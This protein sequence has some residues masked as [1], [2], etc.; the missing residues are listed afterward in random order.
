MYVRKTSV[1]AITTTNCLIAGGERKRNEKLLSSPLLGS[2][3][4]RHP[5]QHRTRCRGHGGK[6]TTVLRTE[7]ERVK[8]VR[9]LCE[10]RKDLSE[11]NFKPLIIIHTEKDTEAPYMSVKM[12]DMESGA[13]EILMFFL[14]RSRYGDSGSSDTRT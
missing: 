4:Q 14:G 1:Y 5:Q 2:K 8:I 12:R 11:G 10:S 9:G 3:A 6:K 7:F 13:I